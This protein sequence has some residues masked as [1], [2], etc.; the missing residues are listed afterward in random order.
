MYSVDMLRHRLIPVFCS[1]C[2]LVIVFHVDPLFKV[3]LDTINFVF[4]YQ[5]HVVATASCKHV[6]FSVLQHYRSS[7]T[8]SLLRWR[9]GAVSRVSDL[10]SRG[11]GFEFRPGMRRNLWV[12]FSHLCA[13]VHQAVQVGTGQRAVMPCG[14]GVKAGMFRVWVAGKTV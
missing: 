11:R 14:W 6:S 7:F 13:S 2:D 4:Q 5:H 12:S 1:C 9:R 10:R 8:A 3:V